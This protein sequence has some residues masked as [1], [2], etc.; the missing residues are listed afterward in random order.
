MAVKTIIIAAALL[1]GL[2]SFAQ[3]QQV[4]Y[5]PSQ[6]KLIPESRLKAASELLAAT[7]L[8]TQ[9]DA[10]YSTMIDANSAQIPAD[11]KAKFKE[12]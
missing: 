7:G 3:A 2:G 10:M 6:E 4:A 9:M 5:P 12:L 1:C 11:K 8:S